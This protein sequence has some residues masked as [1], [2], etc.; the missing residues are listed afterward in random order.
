MT[1]QFQYHLDQIYNKTI[2][3]WKLL[4]LEIKSNQVHTYYA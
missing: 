3:V 2:L 1:I 4:P